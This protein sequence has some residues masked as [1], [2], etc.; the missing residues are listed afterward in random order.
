MYP[1]GE[2]ALEFQDLLRKHPPQ[3]ATRGAAS[4]WL[5]H[6][7][8]QVNIRLGKDEFGTSC[9]YSSAHHLHQGANPRSGLADCSSVEG[10][11]DCGCKDDPPAGE[12]T[13]TD[14]SRRDPLTGLELIGG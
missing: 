1:C 13:E 12:E 9:S 6:V 5:C 14:A 8:N 4:L 10:L 2:C 3:T 11:Y 7:H